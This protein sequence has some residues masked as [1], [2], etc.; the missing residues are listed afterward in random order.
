M[1]EEWTISVKQL[2]A[3]YALDD[4]GSKGMFTAGKTTAAK[5]T[6]QTAEALESRGLATITVDGGE[7]HV[8]VTDKG[9]EYAA[10]MRRQGRL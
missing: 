5:I 1:A 3:L 10:Q 2:R 9:H 7:Y 8:F 6:Y 4:R